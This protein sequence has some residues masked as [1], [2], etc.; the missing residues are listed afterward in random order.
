M[1]DA[2]DL[3]L[4]ERV[5]EMQ[6]YHDSPMKLLPFALYALASIESERMEEYRKACATELEDDRVQLPSRWD[7]HDESLRAIVRSHVNLGQQGKLDPTYFIV[8]AYADSSTVVLVTLE[9]DGLDCKPDLFWAPMDQ[10]GML[11]TNFQIDNIDWAEAKEEDLGGPQRP[12]SDQ[13]DPSPNEEESSDEPT[14][15]QDY[16]D[17]PPVG[18]HVQLYAVDG[19]DEDGLVYQ[20]Q[21]GTDSHKRDRSQH[22]C[23]LHHL[24]IAAGHD[25]AREAANLHPSRCLQH[26]TL[27]KN[28][29]IIADTPD[30]EQQGVQLVHTD[31]DGD[32]KGKTNK[33]L[34][35]VGKNASIQTQRAQVPQIAKRAAVATLL[36]MAQGYEKWMPRHKT[37]AVYGTAYSDGD[38]AI[39]K[40]IDPGWSKRGHGEARVVSCGPLAASEAGTPQSWRDIFEQHIAACKQYKFQ[41]A[42]VPQYLIWCG[43]QPATPDSQVLIVQ[44]DWDGSEQSAGT[45]L[46]DAETTSTVCRA[47]ARYAHRIVSD[48]VDGNKAW[49]GTSLASLSA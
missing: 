11:C 40:A 24:S 32:V 8:A 25:P 19:V 46:E 17:P 45:M 37:F 42:F 15:S 28:Y 3:S 12:K 1:S 10:S 35:K 34:L 2:P 29:F 41:P 36:M 48:V 4:P 49:S 6:R 22:V 38:I 21:P 18:F 39:S 26:L 30:W 31:W 27:Q 16:G 14:S 43:E 23:R 13:Q 20:I 5:P 44:V 33:E 7:F 47:T 9:D